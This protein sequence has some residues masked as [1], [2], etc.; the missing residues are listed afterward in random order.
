MWNLLYKLA[1][2]RFFYQY[3]TRLLPW[4]WTIFSI[5]A[6]YTLIG[7]LYLAPPDYQQG[8]AFRI[9]YIHV[10]SAALSLAIYVFMAFTAILNLVWHIKLADIFSQ[11]C[12]KLGA[13]LTLLA[14][15]SGALWGKPM[16]GTWWVWDARLTSELIL[17]FIYLAIIVLRQCIPDVERAGRAC[18]I[19]T[20]VG[21]VDLPIIHYSVYW[22]NTLH[23]QATLFQFAKPNIVSSMLYPLLASLIAF[24]SYAILVI[25]IQARYEVL[26]RNKESQWAM[27]FLIG[28]SRE[29]YA[30]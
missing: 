8:D 24:M 28:P 22:W 26:K 12:A 16:W 7:A 1:S 29:H 2:P 15:V 9:I 6:G 3:S 21:L 10:P 27:Q 18:S 13:W 25:L 19:L 14:L 5:S 30:E 17:L 4:F 23:Q 11:V 20:L